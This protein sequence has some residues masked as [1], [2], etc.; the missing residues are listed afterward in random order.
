MIAALY[1]E[2]EPYAAVPQ[3]AAE[4][5]RAFIEATS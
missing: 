5:V 3:L 1:N 2:I 4:F